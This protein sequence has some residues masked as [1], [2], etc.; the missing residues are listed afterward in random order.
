MSV[1][2]EFCYTKQI[3]QQVNADNKALDTLVIKAQTV[4]KLVSSSSAICEE[5]KVNER[6]L[7]NFQNRQA[8]V[9]AKNNLSKDSFCP[10]KIS[11]ELERKA[12]ESTK[13]INRQKESKEAPPSTKCIAEGCS[14]KSL[15]KCIR[16]S[17]VVYCS[18]GHRLGDWLRHRQVECLKLYPNADPVSRN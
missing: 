9:S 17:K 14:A 8:V 16:C 12:I 1:K 4:T 2:I 13:E 18:K 15:E 11:Q 5:F 3:M 10:P 7:S 6:V